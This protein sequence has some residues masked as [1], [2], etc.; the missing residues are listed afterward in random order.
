MSKLER[1]VVFVGVGSGATV[2]YLKEV[3]KV[4]DKLLVTQDMIPAADDYSA[5]WVMLDEVYEV[6]SI[7]NYEA[8]GTIYKHLSVH[9]AS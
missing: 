4:G 3:P 2:L 8:N 1:I 7:S 5:A 9:K 6:T